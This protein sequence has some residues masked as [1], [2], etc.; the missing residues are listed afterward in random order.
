MNT[1]ILTYKECYLHQNTH[2][3]LAIRRRVNKCVISL[4][5]LSIHSYSHSFLE[6]SI[7]FH[8]LV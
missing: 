5:H 2:L 4:Y 7:A 1:G 6:S 8:K 3:V